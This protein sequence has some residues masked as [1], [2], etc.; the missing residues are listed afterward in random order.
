MADPK[1]EERKKASEARAERNKKSGKPSHADRV[2]ARAEAEKKAGTK[3][4]A[5]FRR[6]ET[7]SVADRLGRRDVPFRTTDR[8]DMDKLKREN[9]TSVDNDKIHES[10]PHAESQAPPDRRP[11]PFATSRRGFDESKHP[12]VR[13]GSEGGGRFA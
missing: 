1:A 2:A 11:Q 6:T 10:K 4:K 13:R 12:R 3:N 8:P 9:E 5:L 7:G